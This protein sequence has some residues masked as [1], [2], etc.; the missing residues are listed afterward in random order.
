ML[1][2]N[3][4]PLRPTQFAE[5]RLIT[6]ILDNTYPARSALPNERELALQLGVTRPTLRETLQRLSAEGWITIRHGKPTMVNEYWIDGG[7]GMLG[8]MARYAEFLPDGFITNLLEVRLNILPACA[9]AAAAFA[10]S[11]L[12]EHL[13]HA[14]VLEDSA[15]T[16]V[17]FDWHLQELFVRN[18]RN[19]IYPLILND[20]KQI[21]KRLAVGYFSLEIARKSSSEYY[22]DLLSALPGDLDMVEGTVRAVMKKS[23]EIWFE[24]QPAQPV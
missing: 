3:E 1:Q 8:T 14:P 5:N 4:Q 19:I 12:A 20:F 13:S 9:R 10:P 22:H 23:I 11:V 7:L 6:A 16:F 21:Y 24:I 15:E 18:C 2:N 17:A